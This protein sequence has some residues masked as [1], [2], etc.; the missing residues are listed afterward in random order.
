M[1]HDNFPGVK[2]GKSV[3]IPQ[4]EEFIALDWSGAA[5]GYTGIAVAVCKTGRTAPQLVASQGS[6]HW[7]RE[8][9][10]NWLK[11]RLHRRQRTLVGFD[12]A[13]GFPFEDCGYLGGKAIGTDDIFA[14][15]SL[16]EST[17]AGEPD[18]GC[19]RF[20]GHPDYAGLFW[21]AGLKPKEWMERKR[22]TEHACAESTKTR[23]DTLYKLLHSKQVGKASITGMRVLHH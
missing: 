6:R 3:A 1:R 7:T 9:V 19:M 15:W 5:H 8:G 18:F 12:F 13:F 11:V 20:V 23:P 21:S 17:S 22:M 14:L 4:F 2:K 10:A 16:I